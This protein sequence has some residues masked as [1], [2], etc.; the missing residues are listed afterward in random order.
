[1][2]D[3][4]FETYEFGLAHVRFLTKEI[5]RITAISLS[6]GRLP[7]LFLLGLISA[8]D[9]FFS[10]LIRVVFLTRPEL[11]SS[12]EKNI[13]FR[14]LVELGSVDEARERIIEKEIETIMRSSHA[15]QLSWLEKQL[16]IRLRKD[17]DIWP[18]FIEVCE[19]RNLITHTDG[20]VSSQYI[21]A[22]REHGYEVAEI[23]IGISWRFVLHTSRKPFS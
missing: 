12:S 19:R 23:K 5:E 17:L 9:A 22:C 1:M 21:T 20:I 16:K 18:D 8:Y 13:S 6:I 3:E 14:D 7:N 4:E 2:E 11:L 15:D 10:G